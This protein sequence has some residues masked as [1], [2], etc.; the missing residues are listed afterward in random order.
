MTKSGVRRLKQNTNTMWK[1]TLLLKQAPSVVFKTPKYIVV[2]LGT[3]EMDTV[4]EKCSRGYFSNSSSAL[5]TCVKHQECSSD[6][7]TLLPGTIHHDTLCRSCES[8]YG[9]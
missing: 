1:H 5:E 3:S 6:Q 7:I 8:V 9:V 4:C 2:F